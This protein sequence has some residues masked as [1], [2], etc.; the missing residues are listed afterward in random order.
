MKRLLPLVLTS[1]LECPEYKNET[2]IRSSEEK[3]DY[4]YRATLRNGCHLGVDTRAGYEVGRG[5]ETMRLFLEMEGS[6]VDAGLNLLFGLMFYSRF[7]P[8]RVLIAAQRTMKLL[9]DQVHDGENICA[10]LA[11]RMIL[12]DESCYNCFDHVCIEEVFYIDSH[13]TLV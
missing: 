1:V 3:I 7:T 5:C 13:E 4:L 12:T 8:Q 2:L 10:V 11:R 9:D 6:D